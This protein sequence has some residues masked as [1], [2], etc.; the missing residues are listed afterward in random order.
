MPDGVEVVDDFEI[1]RYL[2]T[3][4]ESARLDHRF[5]RG[6]SDVTANYSM[7]EDGGVRVLNGGRNADGEW[8]KP[9]AG[10]TLWTGRKSA[11]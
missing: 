9:W 1:E 5:E 6:L 4:Y 7:R 8:W 2:G 11:A 10:P 3:W